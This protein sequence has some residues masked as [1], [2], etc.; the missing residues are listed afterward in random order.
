MPRVI[1]HR[2]DLTFLSIYEVYKDI[3]LLTNTTCGDTLPTTPFQFQLPPVAAEQEKDLHERTSRDE[4]KRQR[5]A[6][7]ALSKGR[8][9]QRGPPPDPEA[10]DS[11]E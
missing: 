10:K 11:S 9:R 2:Y 7:P 6:S 8:K 4:A 3:L 5:S 1:Y